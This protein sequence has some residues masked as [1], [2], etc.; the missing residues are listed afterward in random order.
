MCVCV[1][2]CVCVRMGLCLFAGDFPAA[3]AIRVGSSVVC[4]GSLVSR[5][6]VMTAAHCFQPGDSLS[7]VTV[8][9][10]RISLTDT[11]R[12]SPLE[13]SSPPF[14]IPFLHHLGRMCT[15]SFSVVSCGSM[16]ECACSISVSACVHAVFVCVWLRVYVCVV[17]APLC[18][19]SVWG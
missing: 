6:V 4:S 2:V 16:F 17:D 3:A 13:T 15:P 12:A 19:P 8:T 11:V 10:G 1:C 18:V 7:S 5:T 9:V 14:H